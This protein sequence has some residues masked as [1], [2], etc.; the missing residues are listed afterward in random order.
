[1][2]CVLYL[3]Y[4]Y[5]RKFETIHTINTNEGGEIIQIPT[6]TY[7]ELFK[8]RLCIVFSFSWFQLTN[9]RN[10]IYLQ[11]LDTKIIPIV[12]SSWPLIFSKGNSFK[13]KNEATID[14]IPGGCANEFDAKFSQTFLDVAIVT[15][16]FSLIKFAK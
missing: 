7:T 6:Y 10:C 4:V 16:N 15:Q 5:C 1:M 2:C 3:I 11:T 13:W 14:K 8:C 9:E 12:I